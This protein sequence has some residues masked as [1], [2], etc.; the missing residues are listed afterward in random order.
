MS[1]PTYDYAVIVQLRL[2]GVI[3]T[4]ARSDTYLRP[5][6][7]DLDGSGIYVESVFSSCYA[8]VTFRF[9]VQ[10]SMGPGPCLYDSAPEEFLD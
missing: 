7:G 1:L 8:N 6:S 2:D 10:G 9:S 5:Y 4:V 3:S